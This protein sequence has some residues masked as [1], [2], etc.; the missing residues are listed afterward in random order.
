MACVVHG[1]IDHDIEDLRRMGVR[2]DGVVWR[3]KG[4]V[5]VVALPVVGVRPRLSGRFCARVG[6][7]VVY[8]SQ[9]LR[10]QWEIADRGDVGAHP[11]G[12]FCL[13]VR[14]D[15]DIGALANLQAKSV[16]QTKAVPNNGV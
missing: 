8:L 1:V 5:V 10:L 4:E 13:S 6:A 14:L 12:A 15:Y 3:R 11:V 7:V 16:E 2:R 9:G